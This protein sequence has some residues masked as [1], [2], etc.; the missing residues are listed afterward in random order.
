MLMQS[1][2]LGEKGI[3]YPQFVMLLQILATN[4]NK[5]VEEFVGRLY[6]LGGLNKQELMEKVVKPYKVCSSSRIEC[7]RNI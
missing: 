4:T 2:P 7:C 1:K 3:Q 5:P 6:D